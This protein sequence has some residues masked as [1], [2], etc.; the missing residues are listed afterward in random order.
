MGII[1]INNL[2]KKF[3]IEQN[4]NEG[5]T[6]FRDLIYNNAKRGLDAI[7]FKNKVNIDKSEFWALKNIDLQINQGESVAII[8]KNGAGKSTLLKVL[9][10]ITEPTVGKIEINGRLAS[11]LEVGTGFHPELSGRENIFLNG[12]ILGMTR[13]E[14]RAKFD[15][16]VQFS[17]VEKFID[18]P[19]KRYSSGMYVRLAFAVAAHLES[20][21]LI[22]DEVLA[23][24]DSEFQKKCL[25][26][27]DEVSKQ[28]GKTILFVSHNML[29]AR[30]LCTKGIYLNKG[31]IDFIGE[32]DEVIE[33][34]ESKDNNKEFT[35]IFINEISAVVTSILINPSKNGKVRPKEELII[36]I[37]I[38][39]KIE[40][41][42]IGIELIITHGDTH[43]LL[44][45]TNTKTRK[46]LDVKLKIG[47]NKFVCKIKQLDLASGVY[48]IGFGIDQPFS[49]FYF[50]E[51]NL[52]Q[53]NIEEDIISP[54]LVPTTLSYGHVLLDHNWEIDE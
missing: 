2:G 9:S 11:L 36:E 51:M 23:V 16:I 25:G 50:Y 18:T 13:R 19:V 7:R 17:G 1:N 39:S 54:S 32:I 6:T 45:A 8:G 37:E 27:M 3:I 5:Y 30:Q 49:R 47:Q 34:Y 48:N 35:P 42:G 40:T 22:I 21:I 52:L 53:F 20:D 14:I 10:R 46:N 24:G 33:K 28:Y 26:K 4:K 44:F 31:H 43:G 15:E 29:A 41:K 12:A 38:D